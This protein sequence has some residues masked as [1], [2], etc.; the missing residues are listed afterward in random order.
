MFGD[1]LLGVLTNDD[2]KFISVENQDS[3]V[4]LE[5]REISFSGPEIVRLKKDIQLKSKNKIKEL[6]CYGLA[7][8]EETIY[9]VETESRNLITYSTN[10]N[11][12]IKSVQPP[13]Q[14][15]R[16]CF[17]DLKVNDDHLFLSDYEIKNK[18][19]MGNIG[20]NCIHIFNKNAD[21][22]TTIGLNEIENPYY[23]SFIRKD[24]KTLLLVCERKQAGAIRVFEKKVD[25]FAYEMVKEYKLNCE[26]P[27][28]FFPLSI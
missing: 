25:R 14:F 8:D 3:I 21:H 10:S 26:Y 20:N 1:E 17:R 27:Y 6:R 4:W 19:S 2:I 18:E 28:F 5:N 11:F 15:K 24:D 7:Q 12:T 9:F 23:F 13:K 16:A 22:I